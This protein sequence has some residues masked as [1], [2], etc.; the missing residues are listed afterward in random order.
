M[1]IS[2]L[3]FWA[4]VVGAGAE[5]E[6]EASAAPTEAPAA[7]VSSVAVRV[8][9]T[10]AMLDFYSE[11]FGVEWKAVDLPG[12]T[13]Y[14]GNLGDLVI[15]FVPIR[16]D[17]DFEGF[18]VFQLGITVPDIDR[19]IRLAEVRGGRF[20]ERQAGDAD[21]PERAAIRDPDGNTI[22]LSRIP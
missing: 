10:E 1:S 3:I 6:A 16:E 15:K 9:H 5:P 2:A 4:L 11:A 7:K 22:E 21:T 14:E 12:L 18:A 19:V 17:T 8:H 20:M 13:I